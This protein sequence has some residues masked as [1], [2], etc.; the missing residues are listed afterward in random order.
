MLKVLVA[1]L[2]AAALTFAATELVGGED[3]PTIESAA[4][5]F[6]SL[7]AD[8]T[9]HDDAV[10]VGPGL[11]TAFDEVLYGSLVVGVAGIDFQATL[12]ATKR[13]VNGP[14]SVVKHVVCRTYYDAPVVNGVD[15]LGRAT[16]YVTR[17]RLIRTSVEAAFERSTEYAEG[18][19]K[20]TLARVR[21]ERQAAS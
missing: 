16:E 21:A 20:Q 4:A 13:A 6:A 15:D 3:S 1:A 5:A 11:V 7:P 19:Y 17:C 8:E 14:G 9:T 18:A 10:F 12:A 2:A